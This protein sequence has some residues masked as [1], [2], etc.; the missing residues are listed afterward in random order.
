MPYQEIEEKRKIGET[1]EELDY[2]DIQFRSSI[3]QIDYVFITLL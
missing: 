1:T 2:A 3:I